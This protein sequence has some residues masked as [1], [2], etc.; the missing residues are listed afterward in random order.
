LFRTY[1]AEPALDHDRMGIGLQG[2]QDDRSMNPLHLL[3][4]PFRTVA[5]L[6]NEVRESE[7][8]TAVPQL[9]GRP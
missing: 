2:F 8:E 6:S 1:C 9:T 5:G 7:P 3:A 4:M